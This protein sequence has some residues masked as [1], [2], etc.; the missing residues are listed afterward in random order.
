MRRFSVFVIF[1]VKHLR[2]Q[3][4]LIN[5]GAVSVKYYDCVSIFTLVC[6]MKITS[7]LRRIIHGS[8]IFGLCDCI[9]FFGKRY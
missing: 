7:I 3:M 5:Y 6:G 1:A 9:I 8:A 4:V 2:H